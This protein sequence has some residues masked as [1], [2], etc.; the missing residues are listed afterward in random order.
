MA[1]G[2]TSALKLLKIVTRRGRI[3]APRD[4]LQSDISYF[5]V[6]IRLITFVK[7]QESAKPL[8]VQTYAHNFGLINEVQ[9]LESI[10]KSVQ[11][12]GAWVFILQLHI[13]II[14]HHVLVKL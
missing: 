14:A 9:S 11:F 10:L 8:L 4:V 6:Q 13:Q 12:E 5:L 3:N 1:L 2:V 7:P